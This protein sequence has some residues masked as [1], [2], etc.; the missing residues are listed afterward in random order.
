MKLSLECSLSAAY[1]LARQHSVVGEKVVG[2]HV[3]RG[4]LLGGDHG[5][6]HFSLAAVVLCLLGI[7][8]VSNLGFAL[9]AIGKE[10][11]RGRFTNSEE[12][13]HGSRA[14]ESDRKIRIR[15]SWSRM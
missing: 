15:L 10:L 13:F 2:E 14:Y 8:G 3:A 11:G 4:E 1:G 7:V 9:Q 5:A 12:S 6:Q